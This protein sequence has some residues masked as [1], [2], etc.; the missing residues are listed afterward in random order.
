MYSSISAVGSCPCQ[1]ACSFFWQHCMSYAVSFWL[2]LS[3]DLPLYA[4]AIET[5]A[6]FV[7]AYSSRQPQ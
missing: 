7:R 6:R 2:A 4:Q 3:Y 1:L 5:V